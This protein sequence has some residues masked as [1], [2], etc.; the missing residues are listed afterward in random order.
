MRNFLQPVRLRLVINIRGCGMDFRWILFFEVFVW[1]RV[2]M[3]YTLF[4]LSIVGRTRV[5]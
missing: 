5:I 1:I 3:G 2:G 4:W